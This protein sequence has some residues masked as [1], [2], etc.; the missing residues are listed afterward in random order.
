MEES[1]PQIYPLDSAKSHKKQKIKE[2]TGLHFFPNITSL[3]CSWNQL[4]KLD[5]SHNTALHSL[6]CNCNQ[7]IELNLSHN[8]DLEEL[9]SS[10]NTLKNLD[11]SNLTKLSSLTCSNNQITVLDVS[12]N[13]ALKR[14]YCWGNQLTHLDVTH[15]TALESLY[16]LSNQLT[17]LDVSNAI[18]LQSLD[19]REN[20]LTSL[21]TL[22]ANE[23]L[24]QGDYVNV[25]N[26]Y[27]GCADPDTT[28]A[29]IQILLAR[30]GQYD[31]NS[32]PR[33]GF[34]FA[35]Q[36]ACAT[37]T[38]DSQNINTP[39]FF[40]DP[41]F[42]EA[43]E[44]FMDVEHN[45]TFTAAEASIKDGTLDCLLLDIKDTTGLEFFHALT[46]LNC[47]AN[48]L[49]RL[50]VSNNTAL[51][52]LICTQNQLTSLDVSNNPK[53]GLLL[54]YENELTSLDVTHNPMLESL[55]CDFNQL[56]SLD[57]S[58]NLVL[59]T[60]WCRGNQIADLDVTN[61]TALYSF[62]CS[63]N[64][65]T[66]LSSFVANE[67]LDAGDFVNV[68]DNYIGCIDPDAAARDI[69]ILKERIGQLFFYESQKDCATA[70]P[71]LR[72]INTSEN[73]PDPNFRAAVEEFMGVESGGGFTAADAS[74]KEG[75]LDCSNRGI[76]DLTGIKLFPQ[77]TGLICKA[78]QL[79]DLDL[80]YNI[81]LEY[82]NCSANQLTSLDLSNNTMLKRFDCS[83]NQLTNLDIHN[84][85]AL[86]WLDCH[87][88]QL[89]SLSSFTANEGL[90]TGDYVNVQ[91]NSI[92]CVYPES[93]EAN[94]QILKERIGESFFYESQNVCETDPNKILNINTPEN[95]PDPNFRAA[96]EDFM[97]VGSGGEFTAAD[98]SIKEGTL[99]CENRGIQDMTGLERFPAIPGLVCG[100]NSISNLDVSYNT[101]LTILICDSLDNLTNIDLSQNTALESLNCGFNDLTSLD[102][103]HNTAL[104]NLE[105]YYNQISSLDVSRNA[106]LESLVCYN[107]K[108]TSLDVSNNPGLHE[109]GCDHN[110]LSSLDVTH[111]TVLTK[112]TCGDNEIPDLDI[113]KNPMLEYLSCSYNRLTSLSSF[114]ENEGLGPKDWVTVSNNY[115]GCIDPETAQQHIQIL[116]ERI[117]ER[118]SY[119]P[120][121]DCNTMDLDSFNINTPENFPDPKFR[122]IV[123]TFM[124]VNHEGEFTA[125]EAASKDG[126]LDFSLR[127]IY[128][129]TG[130]E[131]F[132]GLTRLDC[133]DNP[134][135][136]LDISNNTALIHLRC[137]RTQLINLDVSNNLALE[138][139]YCDGNQLTSL[140]ISNNTALTTLLCN[141]NLLT[142]LDISNNPA[143]ETLHCDDNQLTILDISKNSAVKTLYCGD[144]A[145]TVI[146]LSNNPALVYLHCEDSQLTA[147]DLSNNPE[148]ESLYCAGNL[149]SSLDTSSNPALMYLH[150]NRNQISKLDVSQNTALVSLNCYWNR[151]TNVSS[152]TTNE[153]LGTEDFVDIRNN[154]IG[155]VDPNVS[156]ND[157]QILIDRIGD[158]FKYEPQFDCNTAEPDLAN[159]NTPDNFPDPNFRS[160]VEDIIDV[161][162]GEPFT[163]AQAA[164]VKSMEIASSEY[165]RL[166]INDF[167]GIHFFTGLEYLNCANNNLTS[168]DLSSN[169]ALVILHCV[170]NQL[171]SLDLSHNTAL[172]SLDCDHNQQLTNLDIS[173]NTA[174][175]F[176]DCDMNLLTSLDLSQNTALKHLQCEFNQL[177]NL[178]LTNN[179]ALQYIKC[180]GN[181][182]TS[183]DVSNTTA[184]EHL[185]CSNNQLT[186]LNV[187][188]CPGLIELWCQSNL[189]TSL[190]ITK[191]PALIELACRYNQLTSLNVSHNIALSEFSCSNNQLINLDIS[192][193]TALVRLYCAWNQ[194]T[195]LDVSN[196]TAL[197]YINCSDNQLTS[198]S[199]FVAN[200]G[201]GSGDAVEVY[202]NYIGCIDPDAAT[203]D[204]EILKE[205]IGRRFYYE[206]QK[207]CET[208]PTN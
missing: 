12:Q 7:L 114:V 204:I 43:V 195:N 167:S 48:Q 49:T 131:Y 92:G 38:P 207:D 119:E 8:T 10:G 176:L 77:L 94:I 111:N 202:N 166:N 117:G 95:F 68:R 194:L 53:L 29:D 74:I 208:M 31:K 105:C 86:E 41:N 24:S 155:C 37:E 115:I 151:L 102:V 20:L 172:K 153:G 183:L 150:C 107:N 85:T 25:Q 13:T 108:L 171:T 5:L 168:L 39:I 184:L 47:A 22:T 75:T 103:S 72:N 193:N 23:G 66:S 1:L 70:P 44:E 93:T 61:N 156:N 83:A 197:E 113:S 52:G 134:L 170:S 154:Y 30:I 65:L 141:S 140:D 110:R 129:I 35:P 196:N 180:G 17:S 139:L 165:Y 135:T 33:T 19:C 2:T 42:R 149:L 130:I 106:T 201:L 189:L 32:R 116:K 6:K 89:N 56:T 147:L 126:K 203:R 40:P 16:C 137:A 173:Q 187:S 63:G 62:Y 127:G 198:L 145:L 59:T 162:H 71:D 96:V 87:Q 142:T 45:R 136:R 18:E 99:D 190:D 160:V 138:S 132:T 50:D 177:K 174:L 79:R 181:Q 64:E 81:A 179:T 158:S 46:G 159:I 80:S 28:A 200:E 143:L 191:N 121:K 82:L 169:T 122:I 54:C 27:I 58:N 133:G 15:N 188:N 76:E 69:E 124:G 11:V 101:S 182:L 185:S 199:S 192:Q 123:E 109:L 21:S 98:A 120:Q 9:D 90:G 57:V 88:N 36:K 55:R 112:L 26:N 157:M 97:G 91:N 161:Q 128:D 100:R 144:N 60:L 146:D 78:N 164:Q 4:K 163:A 34:I 206:F 175:E 51:T 205:R 125:E 118:F 84:N 178:N 104:V 67:G 186:T 152:F 73:F 14:L 3:D 148:L